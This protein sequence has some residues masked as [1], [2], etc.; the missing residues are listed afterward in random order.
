ML[1][2]SHPFERI[3]GYRLNNLNQ[4][5]M[6]SL[7]ERRDPMITEAQVKAKTDSELLEI[8]GHQNDYIA[9]MVTCVKAEIE[10][11]NLDTSGIHVITPEETEKKK[12]EAQTKSDR[13]WAR[14]TALLIGVTGLATIGNAFSLNGGEQLVVAGLGLLLLFASVG[15]WMGKRWGLIS[16]LI[17]YALGAAGSASDLVFN[18]VRT[19]RI[20]GHVRPPDMT[21]IWVTIVCVFMA[22]VLNSLRKRVRMKVVSGTK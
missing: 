8:W 21:D 14:G 17:F 9:E 16:G 1:E 2:I 22:A 12:E 11:R 13:G 15:V 4:I 10:R 18:A 20:Y 3:P 6:P 19:K 5:R 7:R